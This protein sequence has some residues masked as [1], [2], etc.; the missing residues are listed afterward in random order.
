M[1]KINA[2]K[3]AV[4]SVLAAMASVLMY[5]EFPIIPGFPFLQYDFSDIPALIAAAVLGPLSGVAVELVKN[6]FH[7]PKGFAATLGFGEI[8]NFIV[9]CAFILPFSIVYRKMHNKNLAFKISACTF[10]G[11]VSIVVIGFFGN[12]IITPF[13]Y[14]YVY[15]QPLK[16][17]WKVIFFGTTPLNIVKGLVL[18]ITFYPLVQAVKKFIPS[19]FEKPHKS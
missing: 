2:Q 14:K 15:K 5:L 6:I 1:R 8:M 11:L 10:I 12:A 16:G 3:L 18:G 17:L 13:Y 9:G 4:T 19:L 7:L